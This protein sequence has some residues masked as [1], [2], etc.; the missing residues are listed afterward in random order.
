M[1]VS[2]PFYVSAI[3]KLTFK[4]RVL[5][6]IRRGRCCPYVLFQ[7]DLLAYHLSYGQNN[8]QESEKRVKTINPLETQ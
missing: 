1:V 2:C 7:G 5:K 3:T 4:I 6:H 8:H